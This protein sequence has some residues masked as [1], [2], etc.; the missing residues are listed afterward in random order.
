[1]RPQRGGWLSRHVIP[2][3]LELA[4]QWTLTG[5]EGPGQ[6]PTPGLQTIQGCVGW[7]GGGGVSQHLLGRP[8][9]AKDGW[10]DAGSTP[11]PQE[12]PQIPTPT[13]S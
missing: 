9:E 4:A 6:D 11:R 10:A 3:L 7:A 8:Q 1:M 5:G 2:G 13:G 12:S